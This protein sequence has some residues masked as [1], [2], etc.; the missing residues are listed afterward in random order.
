MA[1]R[2]TRQRIAEKAIIHDATVL[3]GSTR[4]DRSFELPLELYASTAALYLAYVGVMAI[5]FG[6]PGLIVPMAIIVT[7]IAMFFAVPTMWM[8]MKPDHPQQL[9]SWARFRRCGIMT[10]F[11]RTAAGPATVQVLILPALILV[12]GF[13]V[14]TIAALVR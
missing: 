10:A 2:I 3:G 8:Q 1:E 4:V 7:F 11:G 6:N 14:V 9:T 13:A 5:G 12:W